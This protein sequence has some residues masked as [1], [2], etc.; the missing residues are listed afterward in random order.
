MK[1]APMKEILKLAEE[2][3]IAYGAYVTVSYETALAAIEAGSELNCPVIFITGTDCCDLMGGFAGTVETVKR[4]AANATVPIALHLDHCRT[5]EECVQAIQ[6][7][8][9]SVMI[10]GSSLPFEENIAL[11]KKVVHYAHAHGITVEGEL[12]KLVGEEGDLIVKGPDAAQTDPK[13]A[14][15]FVERTGVDCLA[16][17]IGTQHGHYVAAP[18]LNIDRL[19]AIREVVNVPLVLHGGSGTPLDQVQESIRNGIRKINVATDVLTAVA[20]S[21]EELK[22]QPDFKY[23]TAMFVNSK[24]AAKEFIK[25][26][27]KDFRFE[28]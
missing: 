18:H 10:D 26:K 22:K 24:N 28:N 5:Y 27:M 25:G 8:Y 14:K 20:D 12:G 7:G 3:Q 19:K 9:S 16:V 23:N 15:E 21:F 17:S 1:F 11:T 4:A 2:Q 13:E 6:A